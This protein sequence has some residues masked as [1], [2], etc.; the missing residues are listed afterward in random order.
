MSALF[1]SLFSFLK[2]LLLWVVGAAIAGVTALVNVIVAGLMALVGPV[3][4]LLP[5]VDL[6]SV[7]LPSTVV[8]AMGWVGYFL[9]V[10]YGIAVALVVLAVQLA[11]VPVAAV[12]RWAR[13]VR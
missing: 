6:G 10:T 8:D 3:L 9:P 2:C 1:G 5:T 4:G 7:A 13:V 11:W 12:L